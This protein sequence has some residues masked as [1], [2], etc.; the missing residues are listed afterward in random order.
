VFVDKYRG[1][2][3]SVKNMQALDFRNLRKFSEWTIVKH[4]KGQNWEPLISAKKCFIG[5]T[6]QEIWT[7]KVTYNKHLGRT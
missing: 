2:V 1:R 5:I 7:S 3:A 6:S 4:V